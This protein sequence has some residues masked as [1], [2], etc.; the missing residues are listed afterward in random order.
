MKLG[1]YVWAFLLAVLTFGFWP[2]VIMLACSAL[3]GIFIGLS[4]PT[5]NSSR[6]SY[7]EKETR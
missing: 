5:K 4:D 6:K 7:G 2:L 3:L 1:L